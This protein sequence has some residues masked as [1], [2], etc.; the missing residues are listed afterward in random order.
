M[1]VRKVLKRAHSAMDG[2]FKE[3]VAAQYRRD[4][5][6]GEV[7]ALSGVTTPL[8][9]F[10]TQAR[11][12]GAE[13]MDKHMDEMTLHDAFLMGALVTLAHNPPVILKENNNE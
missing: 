7:Y 1:K 11:L 10:A 13:H 2:V 5:I 12:W 8:P 4:R 3:V 6:F 9:I